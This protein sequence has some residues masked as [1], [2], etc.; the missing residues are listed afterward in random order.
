[1]ALF[2]ESIYTPRE[3]ENLP[4][5]VY[6]ETK[7]QNLFS[8]DFQNLGGEI[9]AIETILGANPQGA[10]ATV[11]AWL[12]ALDAGGGAENFGDLDGGGPVSNF[13]AISPVDGGGV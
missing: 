13:G 7:K 11:R 9:E 3:T 5:I 8:E 4:G 10:Y 1:M 2:P 12:D 6:D